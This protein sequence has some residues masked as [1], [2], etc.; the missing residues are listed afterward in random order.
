M[1]NVLTAC[2]SLVSTVLLL[3]M[4]VFL[5]KFKASMPD[6]QQVLDDVGASIGDQ[7]SGIFEKAPVKR[8]MTVLG[9]ESGTVRASAALKNKVAEK[10]LGQNVLLKKALEYLDITPLEGLELMNDPMLGPTIRG[11][12]ANFA[13]GGQGLLGGLGGG[14]FGNNGGGRVDYG[15]EE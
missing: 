5:Y 8:A 4:I 1:L 7:L 2:L 11:L 3:G 9:K 12:M 14:S 15:R 10:A 6:I 13:K